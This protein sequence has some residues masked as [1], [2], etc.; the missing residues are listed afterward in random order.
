MYYDINLIA[1]ISAALINIIIGSLWYSRFMFGNKWASLV[2]KNS[3][4]LKSITKGVKKSY[5]I[6][7][8]IALVTSYVLAH[9]LRFGVAITVW[10]GIQISVWLW[11][12]FVFASSI[13]SVLFEKKPKELFLINSGFYLVSLVLMSI[14]LT[15]WA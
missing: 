9:I 8:V 6:S 11:L 15:I 4:D 14:L 10:E 2:S 7:F 5:F 1:V 3:E 13:N 12:G